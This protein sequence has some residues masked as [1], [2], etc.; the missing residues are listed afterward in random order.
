MT[1]I[2]QEINHYLDE[3]NNSDEKSKNMHK[4]EKKQF[5]KMLKT[6]I[7]YKLQL[8]LIILEIPMTDEINDEDDLYL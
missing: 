6:T 1:N 2:A 3:I 7:S 4:M 5:L 8:K